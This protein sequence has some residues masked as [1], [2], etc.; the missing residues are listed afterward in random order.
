M[1]ESKCPK[2]ILVLVLSI[3][4]FSFLETYVHAA[5]HAGG[6]KATGTAP[7]YGNRF[8]LKQSFDDSS[9]GTAAKVVIKALKKYGTISLIWPLLLREL[10]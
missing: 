8:R 10:H 1:R 4:N 5:S 9:Y 3:R 7:I 6:P 2:S